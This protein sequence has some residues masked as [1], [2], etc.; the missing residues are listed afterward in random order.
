MENFVTMLK[1]ANNAYRTKEYIITQQIKYVND[2]F[3]GS[4]IESHDVYF[5]RT[6]DRDAIYEQVFALRF[7]IDGDRIHSKVN[8]HRY[9]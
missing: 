9:S 4:Y 6:K 8:T 3:L 1:D 5:R 7:M 2:P